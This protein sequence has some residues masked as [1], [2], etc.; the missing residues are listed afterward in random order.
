MKFPNLRIMGIEK[1]EDSQF[2]EKKKTKNKKQ[3][4]KKNLQQNYRRKLP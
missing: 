2:K 1:G 4:K 3:N